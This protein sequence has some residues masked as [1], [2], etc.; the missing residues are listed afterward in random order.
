[1]WFMDCYFYG[2]MLGNEFPVNSYGPASMEDLTKLKKQI[3][4]NFDRIEFTQETKGQNPLPKEHWLT[5]NYRDSRT[6]WSD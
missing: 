6:R 1:M 2:A 5:V 3:G 4:H